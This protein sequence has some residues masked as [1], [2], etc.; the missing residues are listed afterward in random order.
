MNVA[1]AIGMRQSLTVPVC[2]G[3]QDVRDHGHS[4][5]TIDSVTVDPLK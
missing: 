4:L 3:N 5:G 2:P 1:D